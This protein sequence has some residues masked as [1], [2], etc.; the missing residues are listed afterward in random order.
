M[1]IRR[2]SCFLFQLAVGAYIIGALFYVIR[3]NTSIPLSNSSPKLSDTFN[4]VEEDITRFNPHV[5]D[6]PDSYT[7]EPEGF[8]FKERVALPP[9][10]NTTERQ[11]AAFI[12]LVRNSELASML[13]SMHDIGKRTIR[14][15]FE[16]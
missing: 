8:P 11:A 14:K 3:R 9:A 2:Y 6:Q 4:H 16:W 12:V 13:Q 15:I 1:G 5:T 10:T 7:I